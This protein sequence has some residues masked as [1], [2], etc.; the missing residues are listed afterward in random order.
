M[1]ASALLSAL[2]GCPLWQLAAS[3]AEARSAIEAA[4]GGQLGQ[5][6]A[7]RRAPGCCSATPRSE[8]ANG[9]GPTDA[10]CGAAAAAPASDACSSSGA[11]SQTHGPMHSVHL[12]A[13]AAAVVHAR[14]AALAARDASDSEGEGPVERCMI[15]G[16]RRQLL[17]CYGVK[18]DCS[19]VR[20]RAELPHLICAPCLSRWFRAL[21]QLRAAKGL[22]A[23]VRRSCPVRQRL[24]CRQPSLRPAH[25][26]RTLYALALNSSLGESAL[27]R[28]RGVAWLS[29]CEH[30]QV[31]KCELRHTVGQ[32]RA[33]ADKYHL[34]LLKIESS[35]DCKVCLPSV[36]GTAL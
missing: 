22:E 11:Q 14:A 15:L 10:T 26:S 1:T 33:D 25:P 36:E 4:E 35:W 2:L 34:G 27:T 30:A 19:S 24:S 5:Q 29:S 21:N 23:L 9:A 32:V 12:L 18:E 17:A 8:T 16:C 13:A 3:A 7:G 31:C 28:R 6:A 20:G